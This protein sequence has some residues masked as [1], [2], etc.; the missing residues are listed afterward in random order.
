[1]TWLAK[2]NEWLEY[3]ALDQDL[4]ADLQESFKNPKVLEDAFYRE[5]EFGTAGMRGELGPGT[6]RMNVYTVRKA[7]EG[8]AQYMETQGVEAKWRGVAI[9]YD[10]RHMSKEFALEMAKTLGRHEIKVYLFSELRPTPELSFAVRYLNAFAGIMITASHNPSI[11]NGLKI[12]GED[13]GQL[14]PEAAECIIENMNNIENELYIEVADEKHLLREGLLTYIDEKIDNAYL[15]QLK[16]LQ[17]N[18]NMPHDVNI[19]YTPLH[20]TGGKSVVAGLKAFGFNQVTVVE[21]QMIADPEFSTVKSPNPEEHEAFEM[22]IEYGNKVNADVLLATD[23]DADRLGVAVKNN[24]GE[25]VVLTGNQLGALLVNYILSQKKEKNM[26]PENSVIIKSIVTSS[27]GEMIARHYGVETLN[28]LTGFKYIGE[29]IG[30]FEEN[31]QYSFQLGYEESYGYLMSDFVRDKDGVQAALLTAEMV[32]YYKNKG[33]S[34]YETLI[35]LFEQFGYYKES[36][37]SLTMKGKEGAEQINEI[38]T[39]FRLSSPTEIAGLKVLYLEDYQSGQRIDLSSKE[40]EEIQ[41]PKSN[42]LK[43][44]CEN[45]VWF[46]LRPSGT[47]PKIKVYFAVKG[48]TEEESQALLEQLQASVMERVQNKIPVLV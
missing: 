1:M 14:T 43:F 15:V 9:A 44:Y 29:K 6:N 20:G 32:A 21:E 23:P 7:A 2:A 10:C 22:A 30:E 27:L 16:K 42:V 17:L 48:K 12:Y 11:Y 24:E 31:G 46:C 45:D 47:E 28:T 41:L 37:Q 18:I 40:V 38:M 35:G 25:Y 34:L 39:N 5:C 4:K 13:G 26:L 8:L 36:V 33:Q 19:V 3:E